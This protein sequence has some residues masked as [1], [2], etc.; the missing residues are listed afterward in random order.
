MNMLERSSFVNPFLTTCLDP[1]QKVEES[2]D[3]VNW[4]GICAVISKEAV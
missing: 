2:F 3:A 4:C 1:L